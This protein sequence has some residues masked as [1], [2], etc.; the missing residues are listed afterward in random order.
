MYY[1]SLLSAGLLLFGVALRAQALYSCP[2]DITP[3]PTNCN[4]SC[5]FCNLDGLHGNNADGYP[6]N[7][8]IC[9][10]ITVHNP[11]WLGFV[12][13][14]EQIT[15]DL[16]VYNC[17]QG[18][19]LQMAFLEGCQGDVLVCNPGLPQGGGIPLGLSFDGFTPG[20]QYFLLIDG[21]TSDVCDFIVDVTSGS[22]QSS[23]PF[24]VSTVQGA[25]Q[26]C[27]GG[28]AVYTI[29]SVA[30]ATYYSW[31]VPPGAIINDGWLSSLDIPAPTGT[32]ITVTFGN[33]GGNVCVTA[34]NVCS[35]SSV[36][37]CLPVVVQPIPPTILPDTL[38]TYFDMPFVWN[39][40]PYV[41]LNAPGMY[42]LVSAPYNTYLGCDSI[43]KQK[44]TVLNFYPYG[45]VGT[46]YHDWN[47][48]GVQDPG[49]PL[50]KQGVTVQTSQGQVSAP[51]SGGYFVFPITQ[52][53]ETV[54]LLPP[55]IDAEIHPAS[56][57]MNQGWDGFNYTFG[58]YL[59]PPPAHAAEG[60]VYED[61][62]NNGM[63]DPGEP[64][65]N[66]IVLLGS[67]GAMSAS[68]PAGAYFFSSVSVGDTISVVLPSPQ[69]VANPAFYLV[70]TDTTGYNFGIHFPVQFFDLSV[71]LTNIS[72]FRQGF[73][74]TLQLTAKN[75]GTQSAANVSLGLT[76]PYQLEFLD[77]TPQALQYGDS[78]HWNLG[79]MA[80]GETRV[81][82]LQ[83]STKLGT[84]NNTPLTIS[85]NIRPFAGDAELANNRYVLHASTVGS[86]DPNDKQV[87]PAYI[88]PAM[89]ADGTGFEYTIR[90]QN[91][92]NYPATFVRIVDTLAFGVDPASFRFISS[93]HPCYWSLSGDGIVKF[94]FDVINLPDSTSNE[95]ASHGFVKFS[96]H[97]LPDLQLGESVQNFCDIYFDFNDPVRTNTA[98]TEVVYFIP[99][100]FPAGSDNLK[101][102]PNPGAWVQQF[103]WLTP[104]PADG[105][106]R[107]FD[108]LGAVRLQTNVPAGA[109]HASVD[110][111]SLPNG[112]YFV[113]LDAGG[114]H[115]SKLVTVFHGGIW[116]GGF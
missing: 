17:L 72:V 87:Y 37:T 102:R 45:A 108:V 26:I 46:I 105:V 63:Q 27:P 21:F 95:P 90:F 84:P 23:P 81:L 106:L 4:N 31:S 58:I 54:F 82:L 88:T 70:T 112:V 101:V 89:L 76:L 15:M 65:L 13:G 86:I 74:T 9:G 69:A 66:G 97:P 59:P 114:L 14:T 115:L 100:S 93:S 33:Q 50:Y 36:P 56:Y 40:E 78:L 35:G 2:P 79:T 5:I 53:G 80:A 28:Q 96:V 3:L 39:E 47:N 83:A 75:L 62:N 109:S 91:T 18:D 32:Q 22:T 61:Q 104:A 94:Y 51:N 107:Y 44:I 103:G 8:E 68:N 55:A 111:G 52:N 85:T 92:G 11:V 99:G 49:E 116:L 43:V 12:A 71:D 42:N 38:L 10:Q 110:L 16:T 98:G 73:A 41:Y 7:M 25:T 34:M 57:V 19:G 24:Q 20:Q 30:N 29:P 64:T 67:N 1:R 77:A 113:A 60:V 6:N 48:N